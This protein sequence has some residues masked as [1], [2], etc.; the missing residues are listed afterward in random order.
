MSPQSPLSQSIGRYFHCTQLVPKIF[1]QV[2]LK[3]VR[4]CYGLDTK[5]FRFYLKKKG[6]NRNRLKKW[7]KI[8]TGHPVLLYR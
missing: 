7:E 8:G 1:K 3:S 5:R 6:E 4:E 2:K